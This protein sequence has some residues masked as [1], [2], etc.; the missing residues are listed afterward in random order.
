MRPISN[1]LNKLTEP[2]LKRYGVHYAKILSDWQE[3]I[4][5]Q[6]SKY[7]IPKKIIYSQRANVLHIEILTSSSATELY[8]MEP[9]IIEK[10]AIYLGSKI[11]HKLK[12]TQ[13]P[14][15]HEDNILD[16][17][18]EVRLSNQQAKHLDYLLNKIG[19]SELK[20]ALHRLGT[21]VLR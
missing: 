13:N 2:A 9:M 15:L 18:N 6:L 10:L 17:L 16:F 11:I 20:D 12:I 14:I 8:Y 19:E 21:Y 7:T 3:I 4:G 5:A 1:Y